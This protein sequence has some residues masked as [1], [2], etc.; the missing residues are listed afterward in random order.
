MVRA[1]P[2]I[3]AC[4]LQ[5]FIRYLSQIGTPTEKLLRRSQ[6]SIFAL[7]DPY[8]FLPRHQVFAFLLEAAQREGIEDLGWL[9]GERTELDE[10]QA[11]GRLISQATT[12]YEAITIT[13]KLMQIFN[14][15][16]CFWLGEK[17]DQ[18]WFGQQFTQLDGDSHHASHFSLTLMLKLIRQVTGKNWHPQLIYSQ[19][20]Y[21]GKINDLPVSEALINTRQGISAIVFPRKFLSLPLHPV[22]NTDHD[23]D[24]DIL[25]SSAPSLGF[26]D[27]LQ[28][29]INPFLKERYPSVQL[30]ANLSQMSVRTLQRRLSEDKITY[31]ELV[32]R[33]RYQKAI[34][35]LGDRQIKIIDIAVELGYQDPA[36]FTRAFKQWTGVTPQHFRHQR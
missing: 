6:L 2:L 5:A 16:E 12:L 3:R 1:I 25:L 33:L 20:P 7:E 4:C 29:A 28:Q 27:S 15:Q 32:T 10:L 23:G 22:T 11:F 13:I 30:A 24:Y 19:T 36:H 18:A 31:S 26:S 9:V 21:L 14:S 35:L 8:A 34:Q 17:G